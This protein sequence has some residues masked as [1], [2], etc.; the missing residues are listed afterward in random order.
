ML[1]CRLLCREQAG[2]PF[3]DKIPG[4][5]PGFRTIIVQKE[6]K[7]GGLGRGA[8]ESRTETRENKEQK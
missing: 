1:L 2:I 4:A 8:R 7:E 5:E 6:E 3:S